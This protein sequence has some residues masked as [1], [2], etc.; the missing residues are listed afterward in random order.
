MFGNPWGD[1]SECGRRCVGVH[2]DEPV[3]G[4]DGQPGQTD[5]VGVEAVEIAGLGRRCQPPVEIVGPQVVRA[6][7]R[8]DVPPTFD[9]QRVAVTAHVGQRV[10]VSVGAAGDHDRIAGEVVGDEVA[11]LGQVAHPA[12]RNPVPGQHPVALAAEDLA[13]DVRAR[14]EARLHAQ[15]S[16]IGVYWR[17]SGPTYH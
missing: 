12:H 4:V 5:G 10:K 1:R 17:S 13:V 16:L 15:R 14:V 3:P 7:K 9:D 6:L 11:G 8:R 2:D